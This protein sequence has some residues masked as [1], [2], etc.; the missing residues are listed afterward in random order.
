MKKGGLKK[1]TQNVKNIR[2]IG[3]VL[4]LIGLFLP[5]ISISALGMSKGIS[6][7]DLVTNI[8]S[9]S[10]LG[11]VKDI[12]N[13]ISLVYAIFLIYLAAIIISVLA[14]I[15]NSRKFTIISGILAFVYSIIIFFGV[16]YAKSQ[17]TSTANAN[18]FSSAIGAAAASMFN[19]DIGVGAAFVAS[20]LLLG[21]TKIENLLGASSQQL[22]DI[23]RDQG[24]VKPV[25]LEQSEASSQQL[26]DTSR[27]QSSVKPV[28]LERPE[29]SSQQMPDILKGLKSSDFTT[30]NNHSE[31]KFIGLNKIAII[32]VG[33]IL[34]SLFLPWTSVMGFSSAIISSGTGIWYLILALAAAAAIFMKNLKAGALVLTIVGL[35]GL[36]FNISSLFGYQSSFLATGFYLYIIGSIAITYVG[37]SRLKE[38]R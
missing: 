22:P 13:I 7:Y 37:V 8:Q 1:M 12:N 29:V 17:L 36:L 28:P 3:C 10:F 18:P 32:G 2:I 5:M 33:I 23:S 19:V 11:N 34:L 15:N 24:S 30:F 31:I 21:A 35:I 4:L 14:I 38:M 16:Q 26:P 27:D 6:L 20:L 9:L 25:P